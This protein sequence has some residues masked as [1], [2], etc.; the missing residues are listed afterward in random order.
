MTNSLTCTPIKQVPL[1]VSVFQ[2]LSNSDTIKHN[3]N[4][5][6]THVKCCTGLY[7]SL[8]NIPEPMCHV[9]G[10][11]TMP[12]RLTPREPRWK[13]CY[14]ITGSSW[15]P[16]AVGIVVVLKSW[17]CP[18]MDKADGTAR[19]RLTT[20][21]TWWHLQNIILTHLETLYICTCVCVCVCIYIY[22]IWKEWV[23]VGCTMYHNC[24]FLFICETCPYYE[25]L[26]KSLFC[27]YF[28]AMTLNFKNVYQSYRAAHV[29]CIVNN[30]FATTTIQH[31]DH[32][33]IST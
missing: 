13:F 12:T 25:Q 18:H 15:T 2:T 11:P 23:T 22:Q 16:I 10:M 3:Q 1:T 7:I 33:I 17:R 5:T 14:F 26:C 9:S 19:Q 21:W 6:Y 29:V 8:Q 32:R 20:L 30:I 31:N 24:T 28:T 4:S 27:R